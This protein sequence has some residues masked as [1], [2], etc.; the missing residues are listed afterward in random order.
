MY[1][2]LRAVQ[3]FNFSLDDWQTAEVLDSFDRTAIT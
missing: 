3:F 2:A 1:K